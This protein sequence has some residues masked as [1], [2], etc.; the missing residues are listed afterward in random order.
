MAQAVRVRFGHRGDG[1]TWQEWSGTIREIEQAGPDVVR[2]TAMGQE[3]ALLDTTVTLAMHGES[4]PCRG[5]ASAVVHRA[6]CGW[7]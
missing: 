5:L 3:K 7:A 2:V 1:G 4:S 6:G